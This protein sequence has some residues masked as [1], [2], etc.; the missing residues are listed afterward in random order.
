MLSPVRVRLSLILLLPLFSW[1]S[2]AAR[3]QPTASA[4]KPKLPRS[5]LVNI[6]AGDYVVVG[7][8]PDSEAT[9]AGRLSF[10]PRGQRLAF[11]RTVGGRAARGVATLELT[12]VGDPAPVLRMRF[13]QD[14]QRLEATFQWKFDLDNYARF[15]GY[16]YRSDGTTRT[17][18]LEM[19][20]P[21]PPS[22]RD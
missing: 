16:V 1:T 6:M 9:Y 7:K 3:A 8:R 14:G 19:L 15:T 20:F 4:A 18:G 13:V 2:S 10:R 21:L 11:A 5:E 17:A 22:T 12:V